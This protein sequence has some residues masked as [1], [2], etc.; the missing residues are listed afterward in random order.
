MS[1]SAGQDNTS[2]ETGQYKSYS[3]QSHPYSVP[4]QPTTPSWEEPHSPDENM[5]NGKPTVYLDEISLRRDLQNY[6][7]TAA[8]SGFP[9]AGM[10]VMRMRSMDTKEV[11]ALADH[12]GFDLNKYIMDIRYE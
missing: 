10:D 8:Y 3:E 11:M 5:S 9:M 6:L 1:P 2:A 12:M 4:C 7:G